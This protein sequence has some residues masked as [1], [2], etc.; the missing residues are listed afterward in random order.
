MKTLTNIRILISLLAINAGV[1]WGAPAAV[2]PTGA[3]LPAP[4]PY[5]VASRDANSRVWERTV[6][7]RGPSG[8]A[9]PSKHRYVELAT[10]LNYWSN[11][12][13]QE[14]KEEIESFPGGAIARQGQHQVIFA[15]NLA[16]VGAIDMQTP[17][18][19]RMRSHVLGLSYFDTASGQSVLIA[20]VKDSQGQLYPPNVVIYPD[21]FTD[22]KADVRYTYT[23]A[24][25]EQDI[26]L[27]E[28]P[29][30]PEAYGLNPATTKLQ[31]LT[32]F[33]N[34]PQ[35][36]KKQTSVKTRPGD[37]LDE[38]LDFGTMRMGHG[39]AFSLEQGGGDIPVSK[40]WLKLE[41][42]NFLVEEVTVPELNKELQTLPAAE[43]AS[44]NPAAGSVRH[45][46]SKQRRLPAMPLVQAGT[47]EMQLARLSLPSQGL[48]LDYQTLNS[49]QTNYTFQCDTTYYISGPVNL[50]GT[51]T[52]EGGAVIKYAITNSPSLNFIY[53]A[54]VNSLGTAYRPTI[55]T[56]KN[57]NSV[58]DP[59]SGSTG[60]PTPFSGPAI[61]YGS[62]GSSGLVALHNFRVSYASQAI[63]IS[64]RSI[65]VSLT[66]GQFVNCGTCLI[67]TGQGGW[68]LRNLLFSKFVVAMAMSYA[69]ISAQNV[70]FD[71]NLYAP[72]SGGPSILLVPTS[73]P[74]TVSLNL[75]NC[76]F[77][78]VTMFM[79]GNPGTIGGNHNGFYNN[80]FDH[81]STFG[82]PPNFTSPSTPFQ[83][84]GA[85]NYYLT[86]GSGFCNQ[87]T[88]ADGLQ[89]KTTYPPSTSPPYQYN[90]SRIWSPVV[91]R[92]TSTTPDLGYHYDPLDYLCSQIT[93]QGPVLL[94]NGVA[95][96]FYGS[97][98]IN[99][100]APLT[101]VGLA[102][103]LNHLVWYPSVQEQPVSLN[104]IS[105][106]G[107]ALFSTVTAGTSMRFTDI[108]MLGRRQTF[109]S[110]PN[111]YILTLKDCQLHGVNLSA[112]AQIQQNSSPGASIGLQNCLLERCTASFFNGYSSL[113]GGPGSG[114]IIYYQNP[115]VVNLFNNLFWQSTVNLSY[116]AA[117][118][119]YVM[120]WRIK[121]NLFDNSAFSFGGDGN[122][123]Q[124]IY[125]SNNGYRQTTDALPGTNDVNPITNLVYA[126][127]WYGPWYIGSSSPTILYM[128]SQSAASSGLYH[129]T[130]QTNQVPDGANTVSIGYHYVATDSNG[131]PI[132]TNGDGIPDYLEDANGNGIY[133]AGDLGNWLI[134]PF[135]GLT[136][137][138]G[139]SVFTPLK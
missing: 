88:P 82:T 1:L 90:S 134:S 43:G 83:T 55:F 121:D 79:T 36:V 119:Q 96:G 66:D 130:I 129:Y 39:K 98:G 63:S 62:G 60:T 44:L 27:H 99:G 125:V 72:P 123:M 86:A 20:E 15:N 50:S 18:G 107:S 4:T 17:D 29:P 74:N 9:I 69:N 127:S 57:D 7:E 70:T 71:G 105:T 93:P 110:Q 47:N 28:R 25:F 75:V 8:Q 87:G 89:N 42:R 81:I 30:A 52:F 120:P 5:A 112:G 138:N 56:T 85:G 34:P 135:N 59:I 103:A 128:G 97:V 3:T 58:G 45:V 84:V 102:N 37:A 51:N 2:N 41:G 22:F 109:V 94:T 126:T 38:D 111:W 32:E 132:D 53:P 31:V 108:A 16:T 65:Y 114:V 21:A 78:N 61:S 46:I 77:A 91:P 92:D 73:T 6:Y 124:G 118:A 67:S 68:S 13:W 106:A 115:F 117:Q 24:G 64:G 116:L 122:Y 33:L 113:G 14:S 49:S 95:V 54:Q 80:G 139:L 11:G 133:D 12:Q 26:I 19:K 40:Q 48:V 76:I 136:T 35:P 100:G 104:N 101:S 10:G 137:A 131:N 23:R